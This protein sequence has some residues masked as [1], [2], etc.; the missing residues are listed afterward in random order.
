MTHNG[1]LAYRPQHQDA[2]ATAIYIRIEIL[3]ANIHTEAATA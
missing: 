2:R 1:A 3:P